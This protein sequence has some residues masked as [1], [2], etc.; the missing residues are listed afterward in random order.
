MAKE[1]V[2]AKAQQIFE[3]HLAGYRDDF[4]TEL[5][6]R[7][8]RLHRSPLDFEIMW[9]D[10]AANGCQSPIE[11]ILLAELIFMDMGYGP[12]PIEIWSIDFPHAEE[13]I[14][15]GACIVPQYPIGTY[16]LDFAVFVQGFAGDRL[17]LA[18]ECD[19]HNY[20]NKTKEQARHDRKRDRWLQSRG[21]QVIRFTGSEIHKDP[22]ACAQEVGEV[23]CDFYERGISVLFPQDRAQN[24]FLHRK[25]KEIGFVPPYPGTDYPQ[26][27]DTRVTESEAA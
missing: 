14:P 11:Q 19:G 22:G 3:E 18:V 24:R 6:E 8:D 5:L 17:M 23:V 20:H 9:A 21:W 15:R 13:I 10:A 27:V 25:W 7:P 16:T 2:I 26:P 1:H 12:S 4:E